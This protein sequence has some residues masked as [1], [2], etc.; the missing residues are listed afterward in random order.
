MNDPLKNSKLDAYRFWFF[1]GAQRVGTHFQL[2]TMMDA[3]RQKNISFVHRPGNELEAPNL[4]KFARNLALL[5]ETPASYVLVNSHW[6]TP[7]ERDFLL[8]YSNALCFLIWRDFRDALVSYYHFLSKRRQRAFHSFE[9][10]YWTEGW[11]FLWLQS[12]HRQTWYE[13]GEHPRVFHADFARLSTNFAEEADRML[14]FAGIT[15]V[16]LSVLEEGV[17]I[18][19]RRVSDG[20]EAGDFYRKGKTGEYWDVVRNME[21]LRHVEMTLRW[22]AS[23]TQVLKKICYSYLTWS[24][25]RRAS[26]WSE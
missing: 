16:N 25:Q 21:I 19:K 17:S 3:L 26:L 9:H 2:N 23:R 6:R 18:E 1:P 4:E 7:K 8:S 13:I 14:A 22:G 15:G 11:V 5:A 10:Y 12:I 20:D 24:C